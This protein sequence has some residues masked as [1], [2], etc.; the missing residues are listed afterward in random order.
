MKRR[1][2]DQSPWRRRPLLLLAA[3]LAA[4]GATTDV[5][6]A[7]VIDNGTFTTD[8]AGELDCSTS[9]K[10]RGMSRLEVEAALAYGGALDGWRYA[11]SEQLSNLLHHFGVPGRHNCLVEHPVVACNARTSRRLDSVYDRAVVGS[12]LLSFPMRIASPAR[13]H[14]GE[15]SLSSNHH[16][17]AP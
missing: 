13:P 2:R 3:A 17:E 7:E 1:Y 6:R 4:T 11:T 10:P 16:S 5:L 14:R 15:R 12:H 9:P 8:T